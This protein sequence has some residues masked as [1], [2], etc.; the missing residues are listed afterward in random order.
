MPYTAEHPP[1]PSR[2]E[3]RQ[4]I[5]GWGAD[6]DHA[7]RPSVPQEIDATP[8]SGAWWDYPEE[9]PGR[10]G[11]ERSIEHTKLP[12]VFGTAQPLHGIS[13]AIRRYAYDRFSEARAAHWLLLV[14]GD[15]VEVA[16][17][18]VRGVLSGRPDDLIGETG[19]A[20]EWRARG[21]SSRRGR[22]D[23]RHTWVDPLLVAGPY[24]VGGAVALILGR[25][26]LR[27]R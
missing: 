2:D 9:Q 21:L 6:L 7:D 25:R 18:R 12:P 20:A 13:G 16:G 23:T 26:L 5:P 19:I 10:N 27:R 11:R 22:V 3:L 17:A 15:R 24:L 14:V 8:D 4:R 1:T